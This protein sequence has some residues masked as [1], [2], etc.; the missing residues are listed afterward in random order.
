[1]VPFMHFMHRA[2]GAAEAEA[3][4][5]SVFTFNAECKSAYEENI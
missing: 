4:T 5:I 3:F 2:G 1:M